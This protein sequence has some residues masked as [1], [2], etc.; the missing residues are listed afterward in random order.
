MAQGIIGVTPK[1]GKK[2]TK[3]VT[4]ITGSDMG[5]KFEEFLADN[6]LV[7]LAEKSVVKMHKPEVIVQLFTADFSERS[8]IVGISTGDYYSRFTPIIKVLRVG[9]QCE[10]PY[11]TIQ[12]GDL[13]SVEDQIVGQVPNP[14]HE[15]WMKHKGSPQ[16][17]T[18]EPLRVIKRVYDW[19]DKYFYALNKARQSCDLDRIEHM[20]LRIDLFDGPYTF[21]IPV[22]KL[23]PQLNPEV[24]KEQFYDYGTTVKS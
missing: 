2:K 16:L 21:K 3:S 5:K 14:K 13:Y 6:T 24:V 19:I 11:D 10:A 12:V 20:N 8:K 18:S 22:S 1:K 17:V 4:S 9:E 7:E 23:G 15:Q